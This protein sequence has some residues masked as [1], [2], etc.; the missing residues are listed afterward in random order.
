[1]SDRQAR[2]EVD[3]LLTA[4]PAG[5]YQVEARLTATEDLAPE[6]K[7]GLKFLG[8]KNDTGD[9]LFNDKGRWR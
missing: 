2:L 4:S 5:D 7:Q 8:K 6:I 1:M 9:I 3:G